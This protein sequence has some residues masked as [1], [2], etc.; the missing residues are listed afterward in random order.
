MEFRDLRGTPAEWVTEQ[1]FHFGST[2]GPPVTTRTLYA[3]EEG[4]M[5]WLR[6]GTLDNEG[7]WSVR[8]TPNP[9]KDGV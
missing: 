6:I 5:S 4:S 8:L 9:P 7:A 3:D 2:D 1:E